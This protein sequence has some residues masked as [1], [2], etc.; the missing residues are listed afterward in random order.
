MRREARHEQDFSGRSLGSGSWNV[1]FVTSNDHLGVDALGIPFSASNFVLD[2]IAR[3]L[4]LRY[5]FCRPRDLL[6]GICARNRRFSVLRSAFAENLSDRY[7]LFPTGNRVFSGRCLAAKLPALARWTL[8]YRHT[9]ILVL[10]RD[11]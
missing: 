1:Y 6:A 2:H 10:F 7:S 4:Y 11:G 3:R 8:F 9:S 5:R